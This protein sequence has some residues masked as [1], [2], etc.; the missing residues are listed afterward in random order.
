MS[1]TRSWLRQ[2]EIAGLAALGAV[3]GLLAAAGPAAAS[4]TAGRAPAVTGV[5]STVAGGV[6][7][8]G[9]AT[10]EP[11]TLPCGVA[12]GDGFL[13]AAD[14]SS[15]EFPFLGTPGEV[16]K[17][18]LASGWL[19]T[20]AGT[21]EAGPLGD[22]GPAAKAS[23]G[24]ACGVAVDGAGNLVISD[25]LNDRVRVVA[26]STGRFYGLAMTAGRIYTVAGDGTRG[27]S[28]DGG[29][30]ISAELN[31]PGGVAVDG[32]GNL[33][34]GVTGNERVRMVAAGTGTF[35]GQP[36][37][38]GDIYTVAGDGTRGFSGDGGP[39]ASA[40]LSRPAGVAVDG[41]GNL[42]I[43]DAA[44]NRV[45]VVAAAPGT[46]FGQPM[47]AG[48]IYTVAGGGTA[49]RGDGGPATSA[50][51]NLGTLGGVAVD[52]AGNLVIADSY[53]D[54]VRVVAASSGSFYGQPMATGDIYT[55]AGT[56]ST[57]FV[58]AGNRGLATRAVLAPP[59]G[60]VVDAAGNLLIADPAANQVQA[61]AASTGTFFGQAMTAGH[62]YAVAGDGALGYSGDGVPAIST[63]LADPQGVAVDSAGNLLIADTDDARVRVVAAST[64]TFY[65]QAMTAGDIYTVAGDG[66]GG[67]VGNGGPATSA[68]LYDPENVTVDGAGNLVIA[69]T[70]NARVRVVAASTGR[71]Y[72]QAMTA[73]DIYSVAGTS[74]SGFSGDGG[75][76]SHARLFDPQSVTVD[77][78]G[79]LVIADTGNQRLRVVASSTGHFYGMAM[80]AHDIYTV[81]GDG[82]AGFS[83]DGGLATGAELSEPEGVTAD[84]TGNLVIADTRNDRVRVVAA[85][86]G[87]FYGKAMKTGH[88]YTVIGDGTEGFSGDGGP[89]IRAELDN[90]AAVAVG[91]GFLVIA[92][93]GNSRIREVTG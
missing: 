24:S 84:A 60:V 66:H 82:T 26:A 1:G 30:A 18:S 21:G 13:Y 28:G 67:Y 64:G 10:K 89:A 6:G 50:R 33:L 69:D 25:Y 90:P 9:P 47:T 38:A 42:V 63:G 79:N 72:G 14:A 52:A 57:A 3:A 17:V 53:N 40:E 86:T 54:R 15:G 4:G 34:I 80:K 70:G 81:A 68:T 73:G 22:G 37:T 11:T 45:R 31:A 58:F 43:D 91:A 76:A 78:A 29:P 7:G 27:Y 55:V 20:P 39:A 75:P 2:R 32:A 41:A 62:I 36:M 56:G 87:T 8:P 92:D 44:N 48:D 49:G 19:T 93:Y 85:S 74:R 5:I 59:Q 61:V 71:F 16:R 46:F 35:F 51:L 88:I 77:G 65:G 12:A 83:G 23:V